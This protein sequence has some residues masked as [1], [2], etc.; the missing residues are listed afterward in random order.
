[1][2]KAIHYLQDK[3]S[4]YPK[5][6][7][8]TGLTEFLGSWPVVKREPTSQNRYSIRDCSFFTLN[9]R[10]GDYFLQFYLGLFKSRHPLMFMCDNQGRVVPLHGLSFSSSKKWLAHQNFHRQPRYYGK[11]TSGD[12]FKIKVSYRTWGKRQWLQLTE[13][14]SIFQ[15]L[16]IEFSRTSLRLI[17]DELRRR[18]ERYGYYNPTTG[19]YIAGDY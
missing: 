4:T 14:E 5:D 3:D 2:E 15:D 6:Y 16:G 18:Y 12:N 13:M 10:H 8:I 7:K 19:C 17:R 1:M 11:D 9:F